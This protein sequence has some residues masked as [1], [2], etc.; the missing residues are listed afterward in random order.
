MRFVGTDSISCMLATKPRIDILRWL[1]WFPEGG[2]RNEPIC[3]GERH[4]LVHSSTSPKSRYFSPILPSATSVV[5]AAPIYLRFCEVC[6][7][8]RSGIS[9]YHVCIAH[10][11]TYTND[12]N[13]VSHVGTSKTD[14]RKD[15]SGYNS[16]SY[17]E[18][19]SPL[20]SNV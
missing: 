5:R 6:Y 19:N 7:L 4:P 15:S 18:S 1:A 17:T 8:S 14:E 16:F 10:R 9:T 2:R 3:R 12:K 11:R 13:K 20:L